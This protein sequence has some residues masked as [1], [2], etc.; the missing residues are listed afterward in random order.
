MTEPIDNWQA[1]PRLRAGDADRQQAVEHLT[2]AWREGRLNRDEFTERTQQATAMTYVDEM[3]DLISD[4]GPVFPVQPANNNLPATTAG[5]TPALQDSFRSESDNLPVRLVDPATPGVRA[6]I[7]VMSGYERTGPWVVPANH[8]SI[9]FWGG[10][11]VDLREAVFSSAE[12]TITCVAVMGGI[13]VVV[14]P[15]LEVRVTGV[16]F[17]GG[18]GWEN[19]NQ[20]RPHRRP[21]AENPVVTINGLGFWGG[22]SITRAEVGEDLRD[23]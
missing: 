4:L 10:T 16:G 2:R 22:V 15:E 18:F 5:A 1:Q 11:I 21:S 13:E 8:V 20:A 3:D 14:P 6:T 19:I 9:G 23:W 7:A 17:M 12:V